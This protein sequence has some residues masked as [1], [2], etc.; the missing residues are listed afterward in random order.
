MIERI[1]L[2]TI[3][4]KS[5]E[6]DYSETSGDVPKTDLE[7]KQNVGDLSKSPIIWLNGLQIEPSSVEKL[8]INNNT[9]LPRIKIILSDPTGKLS[10]EKFPLDNSCISIFKGSPSTDSP[11]YGI[12][13]D[14]KITDFNIIKGRQGAED[15]KYE[16][17]AIID[18]NKFFINEFESYGGTS[19]DVLRKLSKEMG[20]GFTT[21]ITNSNDSMIWINPSNYRIEFLKKIVEGSYIDDNTFL[22]GYVDFQYNFNFIDINKQLEDDISQQMNLVEEGIVDNVQE[23]TAL[24]LSN[25]PDEMNSNMYIKKFTLYNSSTNVN[26]KYGYRNKINSLNISDDTIN[27]YDIDAISTDDDNSIVLK[28]SDNNE[29][30]NDMIINEYLGKYDIDNC[31]SNFIHTQFQNNFN[32]KFLQKLKIKIKMA[33]PNYGL[34]RFQKVAVEIYNLNKPD[35]TEKTPEIKNDG[36]D[37]KRISRAHDGKINN[38][39]SGEWLITGID[40]IFSGQGSGVEQEITLVKRELTKEYHFDRREKI[41]KA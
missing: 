39:L 22:F 27:K 24:I 20:L 38:K 1:D 41:M 19:F 13:M 3:E 14:F 11:F 6:I 35:D 21:N 8:I 34:Y 12:K 26:L 28:D 4:T 9:Y 32:L 25:H 29:L 7:I 33:K 5:Y 30:Y 15:L 36:H 31:H 23:E 17:D 2:P 37:L 16:I 40:M 18:I 10:D